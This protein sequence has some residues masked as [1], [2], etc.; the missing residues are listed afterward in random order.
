MATFTA[1]IDTRVVKCST[2]ET[3]GNVA[4]AAIIHGGNMGTTWFV[5]RISPVTTLAVGSNCRM[6]A[7]QERRWYKRQR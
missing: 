4:G 5:G 3:A 6:N 1:A 2:G 7:G